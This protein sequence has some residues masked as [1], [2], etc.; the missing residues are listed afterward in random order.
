MSKQRIHELL[1]QRNEASEEI[2]FYKQTMKFRADTAMIGDELKV[3]WVP[4]GIAIFCVRN[5]FKECTLFEQG[6]K[7]E[8]VSSLALSISHAI[9]I[10]RGGKF[11]ESQSIQK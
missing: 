10:A 6:R 2:T 8:Q 7:T 3:E 11:M 4:N 5:L 9:C 1:D